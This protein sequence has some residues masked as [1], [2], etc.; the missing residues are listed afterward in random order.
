MSVKIHRIQNVKK[1]EANALHKLLNHVIAYHTIMVSRD[2][3][4]SKNV[5]KQLFFLL[6]P[7]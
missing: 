3:T 5:F 2:D 1:I 6:V 4:D 7:L